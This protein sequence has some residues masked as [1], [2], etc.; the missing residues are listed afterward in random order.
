MTATDIGLFRPQREERAISFQTIWGSGGD[1]NPDK[2]YTLADG[3]RLS[4]VIA[5]INLRA[6]TIAQL[7]LVSY[8]TDAQGLQQPVALQPQLI[9]APSKLPR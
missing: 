9:A 7:P 1:F 4:A 6:S 2:S 3:L 8:Q 5:C